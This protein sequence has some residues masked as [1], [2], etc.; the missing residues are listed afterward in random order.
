MAEI[1]INPATIHLETLGCKVNQYESEAIHGGLTNTAWFNAT[2]DTHPDLVIINTC[3]VTKKAAMQ[4]RQMIRRAIR[5]HPTAIIIATGCLAQTEPRELA[6]I[7]GID[8]IIGN[9]DKTRLP[10]FFRN[11]PPVKNTEPVI[12]RADISV[13]RFFDDSGFPETGT[14]SR[15]F[16]KIQDGCDQFCTYCIVP[17]ARGPSRSRP[18]Q[19]I[20]D[21]IKNFSKKGRHEVVLTGI[22]IGRWGLDLSPETNL[23]RLLTHIHQNNLIQR[24][25]LSSIEP[26]EVTDALLSFA[27]DSEH[28][29]AHWHIPLQS[30]DN[31]VLKKMNRPYSSEV[32]SDRVRRIRSLIPQA[33]IGTDV[34]VGFP[35]ETDDAFERTAALLESLPVTYL[36]VFPFSRRE[37]APAARFPDQVSLEKIKHRATVLNRLG[38]RKKAAFYDK[39]IG[40]TVNVVLESR[41]DMSSGRLT[42]VSENYIRVMIGGGDGLK[43]RMVRCRITARIS[44][45]TVSAELI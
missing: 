1:L 43:N 19:R 7:E 18:M 11:G 24:V 33:A 37:P 9:A 5:N 28:L 34:M 36:H 42:G 8:Y 23:H 27:A 29:C 17:H 21:E 14:R 39:M 4:S 41:R 30:G 6:Q 44:P 16:I 12:I 26:L 40:E 3:S 13:R 45:H 31:A 15:P 35:G 20:A 38:L 2:A 22:H 25:R 10:E 32:F